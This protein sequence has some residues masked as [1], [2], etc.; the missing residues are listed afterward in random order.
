MIVIGAVIAAACGGGSD[1]VKKKSAPVSTTT[2]KAIPIA[3]LTGL[4]DPSGVSVSRASL[5]VK[6]E[7]TPA[8][9]PQS[10][11]DVADVVFEEV[12]EGGIT[13]FWAIFNSAA[14]ENVGPI[15]SVRAMD[16]QIVSPF[17]GIA[18]FS[19]GAPP[20]VALI[21]ATNLVT[22]DENNA[23]S[24]FFREST[25]SAP[26]N[27]YGRTTE[28]FSRGGTPI[29]PVAQFSY[30]GAP[31]PAAAATTTTT[32]KKSGNKSGNKSGKKS[33]TTTTTTTAPLAFS[34]EAIT[35]FH[36][37]FA[38]GYDVTYVWDATTGWKRFSQS[39]DPFLAATVPPVQIS[40][41]N[42]IVMFI[43]YGGGGGDGNIIGTGP[44][45][46]FSNGNL[47]RGI[48]TK[49]SDTDPTH[50]TDAAGV[51]IK[52]TPGRT[53]VELLPNDRTV[54]VVAAPV[55]PPTAAAPVTTTTK[56]K[57]KK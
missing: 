27:L 46:V 18:A 3:P 56:P 23:G 15:R 52:I 12:V 33:R 19:G 57:K 20:N 22:V 41:T 5:A 7:N 48:W 47:V 44:A 34:G 50:Y 43:P 21:R 35:Q 40:A 6:I 37:N 24:A 25:R 38:S 8:A 49:A 30:I 29:P 36:V 51:P 31:D 55:P 32:G 42:V 39:S 9:R 54:D 14:P 10:G 28:L 11:L 1:P 16:P 4:P 45:W 17:G 26:S 2:T 53:W 13:R